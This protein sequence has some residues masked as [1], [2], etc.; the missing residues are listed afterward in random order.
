MLSASFSVFSI[1]EMELSAVDI[2]DIKAVLCMSLFS[3]YVHH[4]SLFFVNTILFSVLLKYRYI[5]VI[6]VVLKI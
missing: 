4:L 5:K 2:L 1:A 6:D 3:M